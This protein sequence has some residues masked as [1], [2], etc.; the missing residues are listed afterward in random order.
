MLCFWF[1]TSLKL[2]Q[3][4]KCADV[5]ARILA[6]VVPMFYEKAVALQVCKLVHAYC[7]GS[8]CFDSLQQ[9]L[10]FILHSLGS[11]NNG[12]QVH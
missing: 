9:A 6:I 2:D 4:K 8:V 12:C 3:M 11:W 10:H 5:V 7:A 1:S